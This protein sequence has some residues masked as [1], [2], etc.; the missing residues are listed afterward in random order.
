MPVHRCESVSSMDVVEDF[1]RIKRHLGLSVEWSLELQFT[2]NEGF[3]HRE[4]KRVMIG[5]KDGYRR[6]LLVH[7]CLHATG[8]DHYDVPGYGGDV[9]VDVHSARVEKKIFG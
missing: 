8:L 3:C 5:V 9:D 1:L 6:R 2:W 4:Q 7:E